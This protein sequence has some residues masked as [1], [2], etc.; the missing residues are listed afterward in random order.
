[1]KKIAI[2]GSPGSGKTTLAAGLFYHIKIMGEHVEMVPE[3]IKYKVYKNINFELEGFDILNTL[4][5]KEFEEIFETDKAKE[6]IDYIIC[7]APLCNGYFYSSF[8]NKQLE[9]PI[10]KKIAQ[11]KINTYD[12][13]IFVERTPESEY[14]SFGRKESFEQAKK[15]EDHITDK[16]A[17]LGYTKKVIRVNQ[18][19]SINEILK[20]IG[21]DLNK[22]KKE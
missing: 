12:L 3:L 8:Y 13:M 22:L 16:M 6:Q 9:F 11:S 19:T 7:E 5:Q 18:N 14:V 1:M 4:E 21:L 2:I 20:E 17:E 15:L 10:L